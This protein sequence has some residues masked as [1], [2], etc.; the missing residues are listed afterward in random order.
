MSDKQRTESSVPGLVYPLAR[1]QIMKTSHGFLKGRTQQD[2]AEGYWRIRNG[3]YDLRNF[4][5]SHPGGAEWIALTKGT[6]ITEAFEASPS[7]FVHDFYANFG[8]LFDR[9]ISR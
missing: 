8:R 1:N 6:D 4:V 5:K 3:L 9:I 2:G 7:S